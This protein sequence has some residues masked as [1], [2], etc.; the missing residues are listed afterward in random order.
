MPGSKLLLDTNA[1]IAWMRRDEEF[2][3]AIGPLPQAVSLFTLGEMQFGIRKSQQVDENE[4]KLMLAIADFEVLSADF[5]TCRFYGEIFFRLRK[6][7]RPIPIN[8]VWIAAVAL[9]HGLELVTRDQ[10]F[11]EVDG[12][13]LLSW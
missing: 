11:H 13:R 3:L 1:M 12:L 8:D 10:H 9:Q 6:K 5:E 7:G 2:R 4:K